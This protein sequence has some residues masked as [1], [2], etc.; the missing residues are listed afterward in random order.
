VASAASA[1]DSV[2]AGEALAEADVLGSSG[3][4]GVG[5]GGWV[6]GGHGSSDASVGGA[7]GVPVGAAVAGPDVGGPTGVE[8]AADGTTDDV[9]A[10]ARATVEGDIAAG[11][12][13]RCRAG[14]SPSP[15]AP[16]GAS[17]A[18]DRVTGVASCQPIVT[19]TG[20]PRATSP[21][22]MDLGDNRT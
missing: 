20:S 11:A 3:S 16:V 14:A 8:T 4:V 2:G 7:V 22:K 13:R 6:S 18:A 10:T 9:T 15:P 19:A 5:T 17:I 12:G 1:A 21:K